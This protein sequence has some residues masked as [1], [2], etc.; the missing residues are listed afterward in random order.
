MKRP[1]I[2]IAA[3]VFTA[4]SI[5]VKVKMYFPSSYVAHLASLPT[6]R[7]VDKKSR[8][9]SS[10]WWYLYV[11]LRHCRF[12]ILRGFSSELEILIMEY[13]H[14]KS[15]EISCRYANKYYL[16]LN[17]A[18][19]YKISN[20]TN[21]YGIIRD[22]PVKLWGLTVYPSSWIKSVKGILSP[23]LWWLM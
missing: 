1:L 12:K 3:K 13:Y 20:P 6:A 10:V 9:A 7:K 4:I 22:Y 5:T 16:P 17:A 8:L 23:A 21:K 19:A 11:H 14:K 18:R 15:K 2:E